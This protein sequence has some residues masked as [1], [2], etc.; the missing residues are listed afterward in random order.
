MVKNN[1][2]NGINLPSIALYSATEGLK[3]IKRFG[4]DDFKSRL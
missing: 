3:V 4:Y 1:M 2:F